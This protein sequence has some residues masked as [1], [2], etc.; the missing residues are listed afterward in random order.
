MKN[1][2]KSEVYKLQAEIT[3]NSIINNSL[4]LLN[5]QKRGN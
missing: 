4:M 2:T 3:I 5:E 1:K